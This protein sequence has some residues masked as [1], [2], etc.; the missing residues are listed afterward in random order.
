VG[1]DL[2]RVTRLVNVPG[3]QRLLLDGKEHRENVSP[4]A[5]LFLSQSLAK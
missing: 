4:G 1:G 2:Q 3:K 5:A